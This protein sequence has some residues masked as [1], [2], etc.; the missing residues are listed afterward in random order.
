MRRLSALAQAYALG[1]GADP[2]RAVEL[3]RVSGLVEKVGR[4]AHEITDDDLAH[5]LAGAG[6]DDELFELV[7]AAALG[8]GLARR[9]VGLAAV[10]RW[11]RAR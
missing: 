9:D 3:G 1:L 10:D 8:A 5:A 4:A 7:V 11:E 2:P 6:A